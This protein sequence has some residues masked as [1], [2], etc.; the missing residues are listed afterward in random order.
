MHQR[1][2]FKADD[3][4]DML[5]KVTEDLNGNRPRREICSFNKYHDVRSCVDWDTGDTHRDMKNQNGEWY[6]V[7]DQK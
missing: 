5:M 1:S 6:K 3:G 2:F 4:T 7:D